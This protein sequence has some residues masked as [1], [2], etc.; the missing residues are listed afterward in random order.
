MRAIPSW[1]FEAARLEGATSWNRLSTIVYPGV[2]HLLF[3][4]GI[5]YLSM[6]GCLSGAYNLLG[7]SGGVLDAGLLFVTYAYQVAFP[8]GCRSF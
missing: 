6:E 2:K 5:F 4:G 3:F 8:G 1:Q 7:G